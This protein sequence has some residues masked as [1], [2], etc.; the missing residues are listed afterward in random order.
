MSRVT[1]DC[2]GTLEKHP[3]MIDLVTIYPRP[4][5]GII[6]E[7]TNEE[8]YGVVKGED[9]LVQD[10][11]TR[12]MIAAQSSM[13]LEEARKIIR[14]QE[15]MFLVVYEKEEPAH[16]L[17][18]LELSRDNLP[19]GTL[20]GLVKTRIA[21][22]CHGDAILADAIPAMIKYRAIYVPVLNTQG[23]LIGV[24]SIMDS[25]GALSPAAAE[26]W[27]SKMRGWFVI[28]PPIEGQCR[29]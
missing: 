26:I 22:R 21:V 5:G 11:M 15:R 4:R 20:A 2:C 23:G 8:S 28:A 12:R 29:Q 16:A 10:I 9:S 25:V 6:G 24:L 19:H 7:S 13:S 18:E 27:S 17:T 14:N 3:V 1:L